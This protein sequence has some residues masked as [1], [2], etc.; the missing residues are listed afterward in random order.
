[1][2]TILS[3]AALGIASSMAFAGW[4]RNPAPVAPPVQVRYEQSRVQSNRYRDDDGGRY[5]YDRDDDRYRVVRQYGDADD[6]YR[7]SD[8]RYVDRDD[9]YRVNERYRG[10]DRDQRDRD[11]GFRHFD[12]R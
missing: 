3:L 11:G 2:K 5:V 4:V 1:M 6:H 7:G 8:D 12:E 10:D 9:R